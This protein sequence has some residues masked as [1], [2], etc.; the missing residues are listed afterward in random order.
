MKIVKGYRETKPDFV[1]MAMQ[2]LDEIIIEWQQ[3]VL[4]LEWEDTHKLELK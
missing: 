3:Q 2:T 1:T 4:W